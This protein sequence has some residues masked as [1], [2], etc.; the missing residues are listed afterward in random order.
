MLKRNEARSSAPQ[1]VLDYVCSGESSELPHWIL[2]NLR[3]EGSNCA[4][5]GVTMDNRRRC[6]EGKLTPRGAG[7]L[8]A[9]TGACMIHARLIAMARRPRSSSSGSCLAHEAPLR[10]AVQWSRAS[11][12]ARFGASAIAAC[13]RASPNI[14]P[15]FAGL[16]AIITN[17]RRDVSS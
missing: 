2:A 6:R 5:F 12:S 1:A 14:R 10:N 3:E 16:L 13:R 7:Y 17:T 11:S 8:R 4:R 15:G 9:V